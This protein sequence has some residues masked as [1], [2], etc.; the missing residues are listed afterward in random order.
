MQ[1]HKRL[2]A[3]DVDTVAVADAF[4]RLADGIEDGDVAIERLRT[5]QDADVE[6][7][8]G[9]EVLV[10]YVT[11]HRYADV[12]DVLRY[13]TDAYLRFADPLVEPV[14]N[15]K[16]TATVRYGLERD[17]E[18]GDTVA[19]F[20]EDGDQFAT[21]EVDFVYRMKVRDVVEFGIGP[22]V[23]HTVDFLVERLR[24]LYDTDAIEPDTTVDVVTWEFDTDGFEL[25]DGYDKDPRHDNE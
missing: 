25:N 7:L 15:G 24:E 1:T 23:G 6:D 22:Y 18:P 11:T 14:V 10:E 17:F 8:V 12:V 2:S 13:A 20:D 19:F 9:C 4:R 3:Y 5:A 21:V 16:K